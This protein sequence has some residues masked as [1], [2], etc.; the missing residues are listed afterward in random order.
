MS[1][2]N[3]SGA[4]SRIAKELANIQKAQDLSLAVACRDSDVRTVRALIIGP[5]E[6]AYEYGFFEFECKFTKEY[7]IKS[8]EVRC[9]TTNGGKCRFNPNIYA[10]GKVCLSI[11]GTWRGERGEEWSSAQGLESILLSIQSLMSANPYENEPGFENVKKTQKKPM[12]YIAKIRHETLRISVVQRLESMLGVHGVKDDHATRT[13]EASRDNLD[14]V[15]NSPQNEPNSDSDG[16]STPATDSSAY[17]YDAEATY[18]ALGEAEWDPFSDLLKRR[19]LWYYDCYVKSIS[20]HMEEQRDGARFERMEFEYPPNSMEGHFGYATLLK[21]I[22]AIHAALADETASWLKAGILQV[23]AGSQ[24]ATQLAFQF[25]QLCH[26]WH[27]PT[28]QSA[29]RIELSLPHPKNHFLWAITIF[30]APSTNLDGGVFNLQF[31]ISPNFP[32]VQP[33]VTFQT[34]ISHH[35]VNSKGDF[36]YFPNRTDD[37]ANHIET[38]VNSIADENPTYDPRAIINP[39]LFSLYWGGDDKRKIYLRRLRRSAQD[40]SEF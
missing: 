18:N 1:N 29:T 31:A 14:V 19:F 39:E 23:T 33:R 3:T 15:N 13:S 32:D 17:E 5:P 25:E 6:T 34:P 26:V 38:I 21:R 36:C 7:P 40:S 22:H 27:S 37:I 35:R 8:P 24:L 12:A 9:I 16:V 10:E 4:I 20:S 2:A 11:L 28:H 30:G